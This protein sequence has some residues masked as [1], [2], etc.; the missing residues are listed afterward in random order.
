MSTTRRTLLQTTL[1]AAV[2]AACAPNIFAQDKA[3]TKPLI[4]G[5]GDHTYEVLD[6]WAKLPPNVH[7]GNTHSVQETADHRIIVHH[8]G[9]QSTCIFD[10]DGKFIEAWGEYPGHA[11]GMDLRKE[12][13][14]EF[15]YLA[16][17]GMHKTFKT[18]L[19][20]NVLMTLE[21][22]KDAKDPQTGQ[23]SYA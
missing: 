10:P 13:G 16:P 5:S 9:H 12:N 18:D 8:T 20:G 2:T 21:Y 4:T 23:P 22:P 6:G 15:L 7:F 1:G 17:T 3:E 19:K 14:E 11:H